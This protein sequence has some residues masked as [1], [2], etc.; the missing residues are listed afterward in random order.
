MSVNLHQVLESADGE[1]EGSTGRVD[2][3]VSA[4]VEPGESITLTLEADGP[5]TN[6]R[7][8]SVDLSHS[9]ARLLGGRLVEPTS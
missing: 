3:A 2:A 4:A 8:I 7:S 6:S 9:E 1:F 5:G